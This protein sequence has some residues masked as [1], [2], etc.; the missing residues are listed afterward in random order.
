MLAVVINGQQLDGL[1]LITGFFQDFSFGSL[2][3][4]IANV[5]R[6]VSYG[7][8]LVDTSVG[9][10]G[11]CPFSPGATGNVAT[12]AVVA[13]LIRAGET[14]A[15]DTERLSRARQILAPYISAKPDAMPS[16][17]PLAC[18]VCEFFDGRKCCGSAH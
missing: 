15:V 2:G 3:R 13:A 17:A 7:I 8:Q 5:L 18:L 6:S 1:G 10:L 9:R 12:E 4:G 16:P 11:G 14:V